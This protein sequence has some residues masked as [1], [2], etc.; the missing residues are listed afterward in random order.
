MCCRCSAKWISTSSTRRQEKWLCG[1]GRSLHS[2]RCKPERGVRGDRCLHVYGR[3]YCEFVRTTVFPAKV[4]YTCGQDYTLD[5]TPS[6]SS[7]FGLQCQETGVYTSVPPPL[8][9]TCGT[10]PLKTHS[11]VDAGVEAV[12]REDRLPVPRGLLCPR[13]SSGLSEQSFRECSAHGESHTFQ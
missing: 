8:P 10:P 13:K 1:K 12:S 2:S 3:L 9:V 4:W 5:G 7:R 11:T 6:G